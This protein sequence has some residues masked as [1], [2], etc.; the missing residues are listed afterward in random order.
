MKRVVSFGELMLRLSP[1]GEERFFQSPTLRTYFGG[2]EANVAASLA[3]FGVESEY[4]TRLPTNAIGDAA[5]ASLRA[6]GVGVRDVVR[7]GTRMGIYF[8]ESGADLRPMRVVYDRAHSAFSEIGADEVDWERVLRGSDWLHLSGIT[9]ALGD[10][11]ARAAAGAAG[12][13][14]ALGVAVS[15]DLN[16]RPALWAGRD[17]QPSVRPLV[18]GC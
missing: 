16:Y 6:E 10:G 1:P 8:V 18:E 7:G 9:P 2:S 17:P 13:A 5:L 14:R 4:V 15:V 3:H 11:P 12:A